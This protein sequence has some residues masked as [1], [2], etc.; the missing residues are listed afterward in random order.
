MDD[1]NKNLILAT[2]LSFLVI[3]GWSMSDRCCFP[4]G[5]RPRQPPRPSLTALPT[6]PGHTGRPLQTQTAETLATTPAAEA[7]RVMLNTAKLS[8][9]ISMRGG[10]LDD[11]SLKAYRQTVEPGSERC[12]CCLPSATR[13]LL[14]RLSLSGR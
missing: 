13:P 6:G 2:V 10:R 5:S 14:H 9:S 7:P 3:V 4:A 8:G 12:N 1:Q 11:L